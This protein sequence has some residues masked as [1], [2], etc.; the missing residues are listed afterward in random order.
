ML[1]TVPSPN[2][3]FD[4]LNLTGGISDY[5]AYSSGAS[6]TTGSPARPITPPDNICTP[7]LMHMS[8]GEMSDGMFP[9]EATRHRNSGLSSPLP[10]SQNARNQYRYTPM[11]TRS[12]G[13]DYKRRSVKENYSSDDEEEDLQPALSANSD[14]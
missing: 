12:S 8:A 14:V 3:T 9:M 1:V 7:V 6:F 4:S 2:L 10:Q 11:A 5:G 13:R